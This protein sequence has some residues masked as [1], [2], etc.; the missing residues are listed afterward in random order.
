M[1]L[2]FT[3]TLSEVESGSI[4]IGFKFTHMSGVA[5]ESGTKST[6]SNKVYDKSLFIKQKGSDFYVLTSTFFSFIIIPIGVMV[7][8]LRQ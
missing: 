7:L 1:F 5:S 2:Y 8:S 4:I 6:E 3:P